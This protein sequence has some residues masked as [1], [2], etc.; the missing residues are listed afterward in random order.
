MPATGVRSLRLLISVIA[1][2]RSGAATVVTPRFFRFILAREGLV[3][4]QQY[5]TLRFNSDLGKHGDTGRARPKSFARSSTAAP[6]PA[7]S[8]ARSGGSYAASAWCRKAR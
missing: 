7:L 8:A 1:F 5:R 2:W 6:M 4:G 3:E